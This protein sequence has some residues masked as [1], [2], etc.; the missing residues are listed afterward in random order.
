[1]HQSMK[2]KRRHFKWLFL[3]IIAVTGSYILWF[4][5]KKP[6]SLTTPVINVWEHVEYQNKKNA[7]SLLEEYEIVFKRN[8]NRPEAYYLLSR[9][10]SDENRKIKV[11]LEG[12]NKYP[13]NAYILSAIGAFYINSREQNLNKARDYSELAIQNDSTIPLGLY[14]LYYCY[15][16]ASEEENSLDA[17]RINYNEQIKYLKKLLASPHRMYLKDFSDSQIE[18][19]LAKL[20]SD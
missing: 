12:N 1:M 17:L 20:N 19:L 5:I 2:F 8:Q 15:K 6:K 7:E 16:K 14:N 13:N 10:V 9:C 11:L 4:F 3:L 18:Y